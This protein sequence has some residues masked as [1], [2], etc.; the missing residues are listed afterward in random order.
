[1]KS[2][3]DMGMSLY[4]RTSITDAE[5][6]K[7]HITDPTS[8]LSWTIS[9]NQVEFEDLTYLGSSD[10]AMPSGN[11]LPVG[12][13][14]LELISKDGRTIGETFDIDYR[15]PEVIPEGQLPFFDPE[16]NLT[17]I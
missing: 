7:L 2:N 9:A 11:N 16:T 15:L 13:W 3:G 8:Q 17:F 10:I 5:K 1:M 12:K 4:L 6:T 14:K